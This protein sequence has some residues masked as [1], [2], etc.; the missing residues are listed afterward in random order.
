MPIYEYKCDDCGRVFE[1]MQKFSDSSLTVCKFC[2]GK[3][4]RLISQCSFHLK[5]SGWYVT[6]YGKSGNGAK[7]K[8]HNEESTSESS[9][10]DTSAETKTTKETKEPSTAI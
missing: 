9:P 6:D 10:K 3:V 7:N 2:S 5:G 1:A 4:N 8:A